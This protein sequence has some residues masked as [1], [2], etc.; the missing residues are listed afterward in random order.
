MRRTDGVSR[1]TIAVDL[2][3]VK[4]LTFAAKNTV[5]GVQTAQV[6]VCVSAP[7]DV[8]RELGWWVAGLGVWPASVGWSADRSSC[9]HTLAADAS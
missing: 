4:R 5:Y 8:V 1:L 7:P 9:P 2:R 6:T 3:D